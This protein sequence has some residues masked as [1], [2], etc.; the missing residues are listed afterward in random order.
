[1]SCL[2]YHKENLNNNINIKNF[3]AQIFIKFLH[4]F[5]NVFMKIFF[6]I[7][8]IF[9]LLYNFNWHEFQKKKKIYIIL[10]N[11]FFSKDNKIFQ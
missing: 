6:L 11:L 5:K 9:A 4:F 10:N 3:Q 8:K 1:M 7:N 2:N